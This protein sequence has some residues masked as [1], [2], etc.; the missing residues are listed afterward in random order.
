MDKRYLKLSIFVSAPLATTEQQTSI[1]I[2]VTGTLFHMGTDKNV[3]PK[4]S[5]LF[6]WFVYAGTGYN[7]F[8]KQQL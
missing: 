4:P 5:T 7:I 3:T 1:F 2:C 8:I 6:L